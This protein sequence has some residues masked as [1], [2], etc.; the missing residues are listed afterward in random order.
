MK[1]N[2]QI[3]E[4]LNDFKDEKHSWKSSHK[5]PSECFEIEKVD[6]ERL[7]HLSN[8][9]KKNTLVH[10]EILA[11][12]KKWE[13]GMFYEKFELSWS[14][15]LI[16]NP[17]RI[18]QKYLDEFPKHKK[19]DQKTHI[20]NHIQ[21]LFPEMD[22]L[23]KANGMVEMYLELKK[24]QLDYLHELSY[25]KSLEGVMEEKDWDYAVEKSCDGSWVW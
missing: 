18:I 4:I 17:V 2:P 1:I 5:L 10:K 9:Y 21:E 25:V 20:K 22:E 8:L 24:K 7:L 16:Q 13:E 23:D 6:W 14:M 19:W 15:Y 3:Q 11:S 12:Y